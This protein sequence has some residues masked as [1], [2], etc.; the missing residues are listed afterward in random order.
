MTLYPKNSASHSL[1]PSH[2]TQIN[3]KLPVLY[4]HIYIF[5]QNKIQINR[6]K[7][8]NHKFMIRYDMLYV[9]FI[10]MCVSPE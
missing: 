1:F 2:H 4:F 3:D 7:F 9:Y 8:G 6:L 5:E 10:Y